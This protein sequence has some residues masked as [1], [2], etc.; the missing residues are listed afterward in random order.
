MVQQQNHQ[1]RSIWPP[2]WVSRQ[3]VMANACASPPIELRFIN[4]FYTSAF[5]IDHCSIKVEAGARV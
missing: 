3:A 4:A 5:M 1:P 2:H